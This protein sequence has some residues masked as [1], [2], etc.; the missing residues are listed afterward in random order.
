[1]SNYNDFLEKMD[2]ETAK[3]EISN[4]IYDASILFEQLEYRGKVY[5]NGH[6]I[7]QKIATYASKLMEERWQ[8]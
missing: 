1:M 5:G 2:L 4:K 6:H 8:D 7:R 3:A